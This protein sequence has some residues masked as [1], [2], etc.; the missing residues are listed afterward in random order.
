MIE[1]SS[2]FTC[3][4]RTRSVRIQVPQGRLRVAQQLSDSGPKRG[5]NSSIAVAASSHADWPLL[6]ES[7]DRYQLG[8][9]KLSRGLLRDHQ[10]FDSNQLRRFGGCSRFGRRAFGTTSTGCTPYTRT[11]QRFFFDSHI[12]L[13]IRIRSNIA[14]FMILL[15][16]ETTL[17]S[18]LE[19]AATTPLPRLESY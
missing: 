4:V 12:R 10:F 14:L 9:R 7:L 19:T 2:G 16:V 8:S 18:F 6:A 1:H 11:E 15:C 5:G 3:C 17:L 13:P